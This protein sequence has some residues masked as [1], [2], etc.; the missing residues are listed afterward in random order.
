[1]LQVK[2]DVSLL[3][4]VISDD[5]EFC[6]NLAKEESVILLPGEYYYWIETN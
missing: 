3:D 4:D 5:F 2:L 6:V 1:M